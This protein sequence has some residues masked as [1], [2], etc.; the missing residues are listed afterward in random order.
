MTK[1][2][3]KMDEHFR[4]VREV[5]KVDTVSLQKMDENQ[6]LGRI[7]LAK[8][9]KDL[10]I[11]ERKLLAQ[12]ALSYGLDP[13]M[14]EITIYQGNPWVSIDGRYRKAHETGQLDGV[15]TRPATHEERESWQIPAGDYFFRAE[16]RKTGCS[17]P[18]VG[19][20]RVRKAETAGQGY[21][22]VEN[23]PQRM[24]EKRAEAQALRKAFY[25]P[26]PSIEDMG[27]GQTEYIEGEC[28]VV[29]EVE[30]PVN[31]PV[32]PPV[33]PVELAKLKFAN[34]GEF[35]TACLQ[36]LKLQKSQ[37][38][39]EIPEY[40]LSKPAQRQK[41]WEYILGVYNK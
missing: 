29:P 24:A 13:L 26:L 36:H 23:N 1:H 9:P 8:F 21:K 6:M 14:G 39:K 28:Q 35:Y 17:F 12:V 10:S 3:R 2:D 19:W 34:V 11:P 20:G 27:N 4:I 16:V 33:E 15:E 30:Q 22:P 37:V 38:D 5:E 25:L 7:A 41:A 18:F 31:Q 32:E 40:D